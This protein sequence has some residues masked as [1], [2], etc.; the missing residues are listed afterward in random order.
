VGTASA[1]APGL[2]LP[3]GF[4][5]RFE[6]VVFDWGVPAR[7]DGWVDGGILRSL[8]EELCNLGCDIAI[9]TDGPAADV[10]GRLGARPAGPGRLLLCADRGAEVF[11]AHEDGLRLVYRREASRAEAAAL[12]VA[13]AATVAA[14]GRRGLP[15]KVVSRDPSRRRITVP[16]GTRGAVDVAVG[17]ATDTGLLNARVSA[18]GEQVEIGL[19]D[20]PDSVRWVLADL[21]ARGVGP[22]LAAGDSFAELMAGDGS[23]QGARA[24]R[25]ARAAASA[26]AGG[27]ARTPPGVFV[28][29]A[30]G[31]LLRRV[32]SDQ[33]RRRRH[34]DLPEVVAAPEWSIAVDGYDPRLERVHESLLTIA[35]GRL[36]TRG[37]PLVA[38]AATT[39]E[40]FLAGCYEGA[41]PET[42]LARLPSWSRLAADAALPPRSRTI[43]L[44]T[45]VLSEEGPLT[46]LRFSSLARPGTVAMRV[47]ADQASLPSGGA[48]TVRGPVTAALRERRHGAVL[49]RVGAYD[50]D[51][52]IADAA[53]G[54]AEEAGFERLLRDHREAWAR[55]WRE[56]DVVVDGD[57]HLQRAIRFALF[58]LMAS[59][60]EHGEAAVGAR[61]LTGSGY[62]GHVFWDSDVFV[63]PFLAATHPAAARA[64]LEYRARRLPAAR[65]A[66]RRL[67]YTGARFP[68][69]SAA[70]GEDV[71]PT[72]ARRPTGDV[73]RIRTG[74]LEEHIVADVA[75][76]AGCYLDWT[77]DAAF[78]AGAGRDLL[79]ETA[80]Y[81]ASRV[82]VDPDGHA[83][84]GGVTGPD[85]YHEL[86]DDNAFTN[87]MARWNLRR[88]AALG[89]VAEAER[90][91]WRSLADALVDGYDKRSGIYEQFA[92]FFDLEPI[93]IAQVSPRRPVAADLML[94]AERTA[95]AQVVKQADVLMLHHLV[96]D[97]VAPGSLPANLDY[98]EP[99]TA[100]GSSLSP[101][102]HAALLARAAR[103]EPALEWLQVAA[104]IDLDDLTGTTA[105]GLHLAAMGGLWQALVFGFAG[106]RATTGHLIIDPR[107]PPQWNAL[108][109][110]LRYRDVPFRM[111]IQPH[112]IEIDSDALE[113]RRAG[114]RWQA[115]PT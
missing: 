7:T 51:P 72:T 42:E 73:V 111:R 106:V 40:V 95:H 44:H 13:A 78:A 5:R 2:C 50:P 53:V 74:E 14:L 11:E 104:R 39:P 59:V 62:R 75:W 25:A 90:A 17:A 88:A 98:Y 76:A 101:G 89:D 91:T 36:G 58:H 28:S 37:S 60:G 56:A 112:T 61:G 99:R 109:L 67:G 47:R 38:D 94:G 71:T 3:P 27:P 84:I 93:M 46:S 24:A 79:V 64:M 96:P 66:A 35:D 100:H 45:G 22:V 85:E 16:R 92:G 63:L 83:H 32:L 48:A 97:E 70:G 110:G 43:D 15:A 102:I 49:D 113:L 9:I 33:A 114:D 81:W 103:F 23:A 108:E 69:E 26:E 1:Q 80:R 41:G 6:A 77:G 8:V 55:R 21:W 86:V 31:G 30:G 115:V 65:A 107:L 10:D 68:W 20:K 19:T 57:R 87:V 18:D 52:G 4:E 34:R 12:D 29:G 54:A 105:G 82:R